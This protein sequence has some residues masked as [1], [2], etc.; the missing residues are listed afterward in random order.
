VIFMAGVSC[1]GA[2]DL[3]LIGWHSVNMYGRV[4][5]DVY[6]LVSQFIAMES[7]VV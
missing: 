5:D 1:K 7:G 3:Q 6:S 2:T 4:L